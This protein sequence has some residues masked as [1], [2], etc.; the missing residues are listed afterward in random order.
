MTSPERSR[1]KAEHPCVG[2]RRCGRLGLAVVAVVGVALAGCGGDDQTDRQSAVAERGATVMPFDLDATTHTFTNTHDGGV[3][4]VSVD[5]PS[6]VA[7]I[8]L[9]RDHWLLA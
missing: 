6:D 8:D 3:Q 7:Q 2:Q 5:D 9:T 1:P 4:T